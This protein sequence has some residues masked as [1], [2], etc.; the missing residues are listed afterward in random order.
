MPY[1]VVTGGSQGMGKAIAEKFLQNGFSVAICA[2]NKQDLERVQAE[3]NE[4]YPTASVLTFPADLAIKEEVNAFCTYVLANFE[5]IDV[6][7][8]NAGTYFPGQ[9]ATEP[10]GQ[11][12]KLMGVNLYSAYNTTRALLPAMK[13]KKHG[14]IFNM[15]SVASLHAYPNGGAYSIT[16]YAILG[17]SDNLRLELMP[18]NIKVTSICPG[19]TYTR[20]WEGSGLD[21]NRFMQAEDIAE[22]VW[23]SYNLS[24]GANVDRIVIRPTE[25]DI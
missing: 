23:A 25:G 7:V 19:A 5:Q 18:D 10:D 15:C 12:E 21:R 1:A 9:L 17:F 22:M 4:N 24:P 20:S 14:H 11:L 16:K 3:W 8:N 13:A 2:R 6:L